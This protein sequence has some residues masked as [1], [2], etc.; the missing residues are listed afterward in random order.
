VRAYAQRSRPFLTN[1]AERPSRAPSRV[2][3]RALPQT[4]G[5][6]ALQRLL[7]AQLIQ[8]KLH[9]GQDNDRY[10]QD[11]ERV[12]DRILRT[13]TAEA[14]P[15]P[16]AA[17]AVE[18]TDA[19][20][21]ATGSEPLLA[22]LGRGRALDSDTRAFFEPRFSR[23]F[24]AVRVH[25][26]ASAERSAAALNA[27]AYTFKSRIV[28]ARNQYAPQA[29]AGRRLLAHE[30]AHVV[31]Q[32]QGVLGVQRQGGAPPARREYGAEYETWAAQLRAAM[33][34]WGTDEERIFE[35]LQQ[36]H[37][38]PGA[39]ASLKAAYQRQYGVDLETD[40][41]DE[42]SGS[43][44]DLALVLLG[45][46]PS[47]AETE[48]RARTY[49]ADEYDKAAERLYNAMRYPGTDE[50][51]IYAVL[52]PFSGNFDSL[53]KLKDAYRKK[54]GRSS[55]D[56]LEEDIRDEMSGDELAYALKLLLAPQQPTSGM[57]AIIL[58]EAERDA[59]PGGACT[60]VTMRRYVRAFLDYYYLNG[61][62]AATAHLRASEPGSARTQESE[63]RLRDA[64][65]DL[66]GADLAAKC[67]AGGPSSETDIANMLKNENVLGKEQGRRMHY[68]WQ[69]SPAWGGAERHY[70]ATEALVSSGQ[71]V[72]EAGKTITK[73]AAMFDVTPEAL[74]Q[75]N[76]D[77]LQ[78]NP[79]SANPWFNVGETIDI[80]PAR[81][82]L[83][84]KLVQPVT[85]D[86][87]IK[88]LLWNEI[89][90]PGALIQTWRTQADAN[91][92][93][94]ASP[95]NAFGGSC[96]HSFLFSEYVYSA[97][98]TPPPAAPRTWLLYGASGSALTTGGEADATRA[99]LATMKNLQLVG[100]RIIDQAGY[101]FL[102]KDLT[103]INNQVLPNN[104]GRVNWLAH[105]EVWYAVRLA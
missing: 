86:V 81:T 97:V 27:R 35:T 26:D 68:L 80:P 45:Q 55:S 65:T 57:A 88:S 94:C 62:L 75:R 46:R 89:L 60:V 1:R 73:I 64:L 9:A 61:L 25:T 6:Q 96:G 11:A 70:G 92:P 33:Q 102:P 12:A 50:E 14:S 2:V 5:N 28:F 13:P 77:K 41:R 85:R 54:V 23:D 104:V 22:G 16:R 84:Q 58:Q 29:S 99:R 44:L 93:G 63:R 101:H 69:V 40:L 7:A 18:S 24:G 53:R 90:V 36:V 47:S 87:N 103:L 74:K 34:S 95:A 49:A 59:A 52:I 78:P 72:V 20:S 10:E 30:L 105:S 98:A 67:I 3:D 100:L 32:H 42:M 71:Y 83:A 38:R 8:P 76:R 21:D 91:I 15:L 17:A 39:A 37:D 4:L 43:E 66:V 56:A 48:L 19:S 79:Q 82:P 31:Q 51:T